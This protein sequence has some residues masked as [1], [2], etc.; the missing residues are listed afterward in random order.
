MTDQ[1]VGAGRGGREGR[2]PPHGR[3]AVLPRDQL[4]VPGRTDAVESDPDR[5]PTYEWGLELAQKSFDLEGPGVSRVAIPYEGTTCR[6]TSA[7]RRPAEGP[8]PVIVLVNGLDSTK[9]H[10]YSSGSGTSWPPVASPADARPARHRRGASAAGLD[11]G[12]DTE[13]WA[14]RVS[15]GWSRVTKSTP[16]GSAS[17]AG[18]WAATTRRGPPPSRSGSRSAWPGAPTTTGAQSSAAA[19][20]A[21]ASGRP[22]YWE[23]VLWVWGHDDLETFIDFADDVHLDGVVEQITV[24]FLIAHGENDRQIPRRGRAPL[25]RAGG[26]LA[27]ARAAGFHAR[28]GRDE[29]IGL[30]H[31]SYV[32]TFIADWAADTFA[33]LKR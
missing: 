5:V 32:S 24:P 6:P 15:T 4:P 20:S 25:L 16:P 21:R 31:L 2:A 18:P 7:P 28:G 8:A 3:G 12:I 27:E 14:A 17:S 1:L 22:H 9:E 30:D 19:W 23:H 10:M 26:Q 29:H 33:G 11:R 13:A